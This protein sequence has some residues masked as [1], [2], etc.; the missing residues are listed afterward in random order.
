[1]HQ[2]TDTHRIAKDLSPQELAQ[3]RQRLNQHFQNRKV[4]E[5][6]LQ[7]AWHTAYQIAVMLYEDFS[8]TQVAVF[9]S[10][11]EQESFSKRSDID[12]AVSGLPKDAYFDA[13]WKARG[14]SVEFKIDLVDFD[15]ATGRFRDR[16]QNQA[17][18]IQ[19]GETGVDQRSSLPLKSESTP[20]VNKRKLHQRTT[21][22][23]VD[24][25]QTVQKITQDLQK[26]EE[27]P[28][29]YP[30]ACKAVIGQHLFRFYARLENIFRRIAQEIDMDV[31]KGRGTHK[32]LLEQM[33]ESRP[34]RPPV[35][36]QKSVE[37]LVP[38]LK[39]RHRFEHLYLSEL[40]LKETI[41]N[42]KRTREVFDSVSE[43]LG[44]F[45]TY[46]EK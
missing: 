40:T 38:L 43:E 46:L 3:Y 29:E 7:R 18:P 26:M 15:E 19:N 20:E 23:L 4:D 13:L 8:A 10:L 24:I 9:G 17:I 30:N 37:D 35:I 31:L 41:E 28:V 16:I 12:I 45:I 21:D 44:A 25:E 1:M 2:P 42:A 14:F 27:A 22:D 11:A 39:F 34:L 5:A 32:D 36:S 33:A 6:L